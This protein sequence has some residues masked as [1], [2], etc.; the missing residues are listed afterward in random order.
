MHEEPRFAFLASCLA[1]LAR[2]ALRRY[3]VVPSGGRSVALCFNY[4][5]LTRADG[6][7]GLGSGYS[8]PRP[9]C[10]ARWRGFG[11]RK[12]SIAVPA[13]STKDSGMQKLITCDVDGHQPSRSSSPKHTGDGYASRTATTPE[14]PIS[15]TTL[16]QKGL[17]GGETRVG[18][19][20][21]K[22][23][24]EGFNQIQV[25]MQYQGAFVWHVGGRRR[26]GRTKPSIVRRIRED[27]SQSNGEWGAQNHCN[28]HKPTMLAEIL[29][30]AERQCPRIHLSERAVRGHELC[31]G[32]APSV[33]TQRPEGGRAR[34]RGWPRRVIAVGLAAPPV[35]VTT[36][37]R[38][39]ID[40]SAREGVSPS[41]VQTHIG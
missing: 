5:A 1:E 23:D 10:P 12:F 38:P 33:F 41:N 22:A 9:A 34:G 19:P 7:H 37:A 35:D 4:L 32:L 8:A 25:M 17:G 29:G 14:T 11:R 26:S 18:S 21:A 36:S 15:R 20:H 27:S 2:L 30:I 28:M 6:H 13:R 24:V 40:S 39:Q 31:S 3:C 16:L